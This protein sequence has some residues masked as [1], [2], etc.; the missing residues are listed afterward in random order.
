MKRAATYVV[1]MLVLMASATARADDG[2]GV[3]ITWEAALAAVFGAAGFLFWRLW[4]AEK[5]AVAGIKAT[6]EKMRDDHAKAI[7]EQ[8]EAHERSRD[9]QANAHKVDF[10]KL[11]LRV[12]SLE[13]NA[14]VLAHISVSLERLSQKVDRVSEDLTRIKTEARQ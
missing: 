2:R 9:G 11:E 13:A 6:V 7:K 8:A 4:D 10:E 3:S 12:R 5:S 1:P 14:G